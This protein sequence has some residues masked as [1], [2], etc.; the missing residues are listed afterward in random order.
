MA[1]IGA[2]G[3]SAARD[4][5]A[6]TGGRV[7]IAAIQ[8][9][10][11]ARGLSL[12]SAGCA[13]AAG[14][15]LASC[16]RPTARRALGASRGSSRTSRSGP[17]VYGRATGARLRGR[18]EFGPHRPATAPVRRRA[19]RGTAVRRSRTDSARALI[20]AERQG[21]AVAMGPAAV[22]SREAHG[23]PRDIVAISI[24]HR[25]LPGQKTH[26]VILSQTHL[27]Y[28]Q[29]SERMVLLGPEGREAAV[30]AAARCVAAGS[31]APRGDR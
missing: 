29:K 18:A 28:Q 19:A 20:D 27:F 12:A 25:C 23:A 14:V 2:A 4:A 8:G 26:Q 11:P 22:R 5:G 3:I 16:G 30:R 21:R 24:V 10:L 15:C 31:G 1:A 6:R 9:T 7:G 17:S 13:G